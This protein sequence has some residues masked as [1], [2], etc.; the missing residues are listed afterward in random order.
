MHQK[1]IIIW[2]KNIDNLI[3][4]YQ[5]VGGLTVQMFF[6]AKT[7]N[8]NKWKVYSFSE[9]KKCKLMTSIF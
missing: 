7:F 6:W 4:D 9:T 1:K 8:L 5:L 3:N 2:T